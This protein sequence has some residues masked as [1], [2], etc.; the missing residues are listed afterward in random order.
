MLGRQL[1]TAGRVQ[2][3]GPPGRRMAQSSQGPC[4]LSALAFK[5]TLC[6]NARRS[7][8]SRAAAARKA[9]RPP[10]PVPSLGSWLSHVPSAPGSL[11]F[12]ILVPG[13]LRGTLCSAPGRASCLRHLAPIPSPGGVPTHPSV[14]LLASLFRLPG[15]AL[16]AQKP[17]LLSSCPSRLPLLHHGSES[18][19]ACAGRAQRDSH[20]RSLSG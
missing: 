2:A 12:F 5:C 16:A 19:R 17:P 4:C 9:V 18:A 13:P 10:R 7:F 1:G 14:A 3:P 6:Q 11:L 20:G 15:G 8:G